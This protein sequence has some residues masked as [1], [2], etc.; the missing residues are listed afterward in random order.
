MKAHISAEFFAGNRQRLLEKVKGG[1]VA[2]S[3]YTQMQRSSDIAH[4]FEQEANF[5]YLTGIDEPDW[6][7]IADGVR[8]KWW[9]VAPEVSAI[10]AAFD[11]ALGA[12]SATEI[13]GISE[14]IDRSEALSLLRQLHRS[15]SLAYTCDPPPYLEKYFTFVLNPAPKE[16]RDLLT[17]NFNR[18]QN[19]RQELVALRAIKQP[20][21]VACLKEAISISV[22][23]FQEVRDRFQSYQ[24]EYE[25]EADFTYAVRRAGA[26]GN[27]YTPIVGGGEN[28]CTL[29]YE[30][31][32]D[33]LKKKTLVLM[34]MGAKVS[35]YC[36]DVSRTFAFGEPTKRQQQIHDALKEA[37]IEIIRQC[38]PGMS[39]E[40]Y[41]E[42]SNEIMMKV[43]ND[44]GVM[45]GH[46]EKLFYKYF[47][48]AMSHGLGIDPHDS[49]GGYTEFQPG[50]V[51]TVEPGIYIPE[52]KIGIRLEDDLLITEKGSTNLSAK[53]GLDL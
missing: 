45:K 13:S 44:V 14:V 32:S 49:F 3:A 36:A 16:L 46:D 34:D 51:M 42:Q 17:R 30:R 43:M 18:V 25:V 27:A 12:A 53:L 19:C 20:E 26:E 9:L 40:R 37:H 35:H 38:V 24:W 28:A 6:W 48:H 15:H 39:I 11:G 33:R 8:G 5:W 1:V 41:G 10:T 4:D 29:H 52:E 50:M 47:P 31:N 7:V 21:E 2:L 22:A 23:A